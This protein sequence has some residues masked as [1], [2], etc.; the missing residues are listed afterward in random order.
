[1]ERLPRFDDR[2]KYELARSARCAELA[3]LPARPSPSAPRRRPGRRAAWL[4]KGPGQEARQVEHLEARQ[5]AGQLMSNTESVNHSAQTH[6]MKAT[7]RVPAEVEDYGEQCWCGE[8][9]RQ[10]ET[11]FETE[12]FIER[13]GFALSVIDSPAATSLWPRAVP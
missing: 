13:V 6:S 12:R 1:M 4:Q 10:V 2:K 7:S 5:W 3:A 8:G 11:A 9:T